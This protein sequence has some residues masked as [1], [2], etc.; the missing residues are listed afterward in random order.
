MPPL[1]ELEASQLAETTIK[2]VTDQQNRRQTTRQNV[3]FET[4]FPVPVPQEA[5]GQQPQ[6]V[7]VRQKS[8]LVSPQTYPFPV[9]HM[10]TAKDFI[11]TKV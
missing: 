7:Y 10:Y 4:E 2:L 9:P 8:D 3:E 5:E 1:D 11:I 6:Q